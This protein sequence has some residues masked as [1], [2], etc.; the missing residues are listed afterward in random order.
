MEI[1]NTAV[2]D[3][4]KTLEHKNP[5]LA[6]TRARGGVFFFF[7]VQDLYIQLLAQSNLHSRLSST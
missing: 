1:D 7:K 3:A 2:V 4:A 5:L 6:F